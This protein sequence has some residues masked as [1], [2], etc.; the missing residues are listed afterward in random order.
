MWDQVEWYIA[1]GCTGL[2]TVCLSSEM[3]N[4]SN[5]ERLA[6]AQHVKDAAKGRVAVVAC[7]TFGGPI[8]EQAAFV[9]EMGKVVDAVVI[10]ASQLCKQSDDDSVW[11]EKAQE[12][13]DA[14]PGVP[15]GVYE[16]PK[17]YHR[18]LS[19][20]LLGWVARTGRF[21]FHKDTCCDAAQ[22]TA[23]LKAVQGLGSTYGSPTLAHVSLVVVSL[24]SFALGCSLTRPATPLNDCRPFRFYNANVATLLHSLQQGGHGFSGI[25]AN[26]YPWMHAWLCNNWSTAPEAAEHL[27][28]FLSVSENVVDHKYPVS[29]KLFL[30]RGYS[31]WA[32]VHCRCS[33]ATFNVEETLKLDH[34]KK[35]AA[36][37]AAAI[38]GA[39]AGDG[40]AAVKGPAVV[41][42]QG[43]DS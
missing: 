19:A 5:A 21:L 26:F 42:L 13:M 25:S 43:S 18:L 32:G 7:G 12:L 39:A 30:H 31:K 4:L 41:E 40:G 20:E 9:K 3:Y 10:V 22:I 28:H 27:Q 6:L 1:S 2:F 24:V 38:A 37:V 17:P 34:L 23:K 36:W 35:H 8:A 14:T 11:K 15:L 33:D 29:A 16:C